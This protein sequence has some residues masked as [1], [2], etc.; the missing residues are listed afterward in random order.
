[1]IKKYLEDIGYEY[2]E[3][4][5]HKHQEIPNNPEGWIYLVQYSAGCE[6]WN[7][8]TTDTIVFFSQNYSYRVLEQAR[9]RIDR[10]NTPFKDLY[11]YH[12]RSNAPIDI[13]IWRKLKDKKNFNER[14]FIRKIK[15]GGN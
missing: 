7:C 11:Y 15:N 5:G 12:F 3:W 2:S 10:M 9:G 4:N 1:M 13:A 14:S 6:G 8:V